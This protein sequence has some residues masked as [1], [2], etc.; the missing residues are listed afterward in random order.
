MR[1]PGS[2]SRRSV[3]EAYWTYEDIGTFLFV[4]IALD[5]VVHLAVRLHLLDSSQLLV[6]STALETLITAFFGRGAVRNSE[7]ALS[8]A[9]SCA[10][11]MADP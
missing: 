5:T 4:T 11:R 10:T 8:K 9:C 3:Q 6:P 1:Q 2:S 7:T